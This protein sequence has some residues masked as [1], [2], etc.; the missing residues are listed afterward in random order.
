MVYRYI[1][2]FSCEEKNL[3]CKI[4][5]HLCCI[6]KERKKERKKSLQREI[7]EWEKVW[8]SQDSLVAAA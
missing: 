6:N 4:L 3:L 2:Y 1:L 8:A 5:G 7:K